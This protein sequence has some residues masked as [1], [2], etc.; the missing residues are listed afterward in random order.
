MIASGYCVSQK[1]HKSI[2]PATCC[3]LIL[4][5]LIAASVTRAASA[6]DLQPQP[7]RVL[8]LCSFE[9]EVGLCSNF[10]DVRR[11]TGKKLAEV[12]VLS[13]DVA[14][15]ASGW[16]QLQRWHI[17]EVPP[18]SVLRFKP[19]SMWEMYKWRLA[20][21]GLL[22]AAETMLIAF[23]LIQRGKRMEAESSLQRSEE[24]YRSL[25]ESSH[26]WVWEVDANGTFTYA[27]PQCR[28]LLGYE[29]NELIGKQPFDL[30][31][32]EEASRVRLAFG[33]MVAQPAPFRGR[34]NTS[35]HKEG[36]LVVLETN[37]VPVFD[38]SSRFR[39][40]RGM[41][42][43]V[44]ERQQTEEARR[45]AEREYREIF[46]DALEGI[47]RVSA[48][49]KIL[50]ANPA[51]ARM[52]GFS[53]AEECVSGT[54]R[55]GAEGWLDPGDQR[56]FVKL[57][58]ER[59][60]VRGF[61]CRCKRK[62]GAE[63]WV[64]LS[65]RRVTGPDG[66]ALY[67][68]GFV[69]DITERKRA[70][71]ALARQ[72]E[73]D[74][75]MTGVLSRFAT[76]SS[77]EVDAGVEDALRR[78][79]EFTGADH[80]YIVHFYQD[81]ASWSITHE[82][83][84]PRVEAKITQFQEKPMGSLP[85]TEARLLAG[86]TTSVCSPDDYPSDWIEER[87][88][89]QAE[90]H[91]ACINVP[92]W[93]KAGVL[94]VIGLHSHSHPMAWSDDDVAHMRLVGDAIATAL[95][96]KHSMAEVQKSEQKF[97]KAFHA[98]PVAMTIFSLATERFIEANRAFEENTGFGADTITGRIPGELGTH[99]SSYSSVNINQL[100]SS[101]ECVRN[102]ETQYRNKAGDR[103]TALLSTE[104]IQFGGEPCVLLVLDDITERKR[105]EQRLHELGARLLMVQEEERRRIAREL[106]DDFSQ[107]LALLAIDLEQLAQRAPAGERE[108]GARLGMLW[109][110]TQELTADL[111]RLSYQLHPSKLEDLGLVEAVRSYCHGLS[112]QA[113]LKVNFSDADVPRLLPNDISLC[114]YRVIQEA[115]HNVVK[116]SGVNA[117]E[118]Q[119]SGGAGEVRLVVSDSGKGFAMESVS[120]R[121][122]LGLVSMQERVRHVGGELFI[123]AR[124]SGGTRIAVR[125]PIPLRQ[126]Q[127]HAT[128]G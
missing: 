20:F 55:S 19:P 116:H 83:C 117:A 100:L 74:E 38:S 89:Q 54:S 39:G 121:E 64:S 128:T 63:F 14:R 57:L 104:L 24:R 85:R 15:D 127:R 21:L 111:H 115:L 107:R 109:F 43:D 7:K 71:L 96:R 28:E 72:L 61:E 102:V 42:R 114:I 80:A 73:F 32:P 1:G 119:L 41:D 94:G 5:L 124:P 31:P 103:R 113:A 10:D 84:A 66:K 98:S 93:N 3:R 90:G 45:R 112:R 2:R 70:D 37:G 12:P 16:R 34:V 49:G 26:D 78:L 44:T 46:D 52:L 69:E 101:R 92:I 122:G 91:V 87:K 67:Y 33:E 58:Q 36:R 97:S 99:L 106:H 6:F 13:E 4:Y 30:M 59:G 8:I 18:G 79:A 81:P 95:E 22:I 77:S 17:R 9:S 62:D 108:W 75:L 25:V 51:L 56:T 123:D 125:I 35:L 48:E 118:V 65:T 53:S 105:T 126:S 11:L 76:C 120:E 47:Y 110:Q 60:V 27:G 50:A 68:E 29:P 40:Y 88:H 82:W 86:E 23:L